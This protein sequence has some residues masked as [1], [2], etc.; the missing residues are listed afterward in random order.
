MIEENYNSKVMFYFRSP[1]V[2]LL[3]V[4]K[5]NIFFLRNSVLCIWLSNE[6][7]THQFN[8]SLNY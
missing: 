6:G 4:F 2:L 7:I 3:F 1:N 5:K 8:L